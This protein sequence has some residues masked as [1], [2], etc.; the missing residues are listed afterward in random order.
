MGD[1]LFLLTFTTICYNIEVIN[2]KVVMSTEV[3]TQLMERAASMIDYFE[4][5]L[6]AELIEKDLELN[7]LDSLYKHVHEAEAEASRQEHYAT[8]TY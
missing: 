3:N 5:K 7:D 1:S 4:G 8:D 6:P 2:R